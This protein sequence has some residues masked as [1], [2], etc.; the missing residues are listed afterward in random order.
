[1]FRLGALLVLSFIAV[2]PRSA[3]AEPK[4]GWVTLEWTAPGDNGTTGE[5]A[6]YDIRYS[7]RPITAANFEQATRA[8]MKRAHAAGARERCR[9]GGLEASGDYYF[10]V[11]TVDHHGNWS[12]VSNLA[13]LRSRGIRSEPG[14]PPL[15]SSIFPLEFSLPYPNPARGPV[16]FDMSLP[17]DSWARVDVFD[18]AGRRIRTLVASLEAAG[19]HH[20]DWDL[21][22]ERG[23]R[24]DA[25][26]YLVK[27]ELEGLIRLRRLAVVR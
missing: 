20:V 17:F 25:G 21:L 13:V 14:D 18:L 19:I 24:V 9:F 27:A 6:L 8:L 7:K 5:A 3:A 11:K 12:Q 16:R 4:R 10:A 22:D 23:H 26:L 15:I 1:M 2:V